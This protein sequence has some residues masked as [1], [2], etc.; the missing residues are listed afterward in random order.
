MT[1]KSHDQLK[2]ERWGLPVPEGYK[3]GPKSMAYRHYGCA[4]R[5]CLPSGKRHDGE[6]PI[7]HNERQKKLRA[8]KKG[9]PVPEGTKHGIYTA[10]TYGCTCK[11]CDAAKKTASHREKN[12]W[13]YRPTHGRWTMRKDSGG[14]LVDVLCWP[15]KDAGPD[16][17]CPHQLKEAA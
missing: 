5:V 12:P 13:M 4:C 14:A 16:W 8:T 11:I 9:T 3:H 2:R 7:P 17:V 10:R 1:N 15:P 6:N